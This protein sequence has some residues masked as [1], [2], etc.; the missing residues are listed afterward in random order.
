MPLL[1][2]TSTETF[3]PDYL[4]FDSIIKGLYSCETAFETFKEIATDFHYPLEDID[5]NK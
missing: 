1:E 5:P 2:T 3:S 4:A